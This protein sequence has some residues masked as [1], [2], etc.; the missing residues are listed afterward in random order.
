MM[1]WKQR[2]FISVNST[3]IFLIAYI[4]IFSITSV[5]TA[6]SASAFDITTEIRYNQI[7]FFI[8]S[9]DWT[10]DAVKAIFSTGPIL[11]LISGILLWILYSKVVEENGMLKLLVVWMLIVFIQCFFG[12]MMMGA[13]FSK[14]FGYV[15]MYLYFM[16]TGKMIITLFA[17]ASMFTLGLLMTR[18][19]LF[20]ANTYLNVLPGDK[21][22]VFTL[23]QF[24]VPFI[25][26]NLIID[27]IKLPGIS[28]YE[29]F[30][31]AST[32]ALLIPV[33]IRAGMMQDLFFDEEKKEIGISWKTGAVALTLLL[34][35]RII[36][37]VGIRF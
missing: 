33:Y 9:Y 29:I 21:A 36:F 12:D 3:V 5:V 8:R 17:L 22:R 31:N 23:F 6:L 20:T 16:D 25:T 24:L 2:I 4:L 37:G 11:S 14:G 13:L 30:L 35:F 7:L 28:V 27:L 26:G 32:I 19:L 18:Q 1:T 15:I 10:S 34:L